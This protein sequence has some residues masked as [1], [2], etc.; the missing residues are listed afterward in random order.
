MNE[1]FYNLT[2]EKQDC[3]INGAMEVFAINGFKRASTDE[4]VRVSGVSKGLWFHYF[5][6]KLGLYSFVVS[7]G[8]KYA[9][10]ELSLN[11]EKEE[12]DFFKVRRGIERAKVAMME[13]YPYLPLLLISLL[14]ETD[15][16][17][18]M[19]VSDI[20]DKYADTVSE[21]QI[22]TNREFLRRKEEAGKLMDIITFALD[23]LLEAH[24]RKPVFRKERFLE[25]ADGYL[26]YMKS[27]SY[28]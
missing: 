27:L 26:D 5:D 24:Y 13:K 6:N 20:R 8:V 14:R 21:M 7:Y 9:L 23:G 17:A 25:E 15:E 16:D 4:M 10:L 11:V 12:Q 2:N 3:M 18:L 22:Q 1:K 19:A 28:R